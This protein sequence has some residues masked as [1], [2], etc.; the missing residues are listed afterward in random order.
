MRNDTM[1]G[2]LYR[3]Q[4][5]SYLQE[6]NEILI[7][8]PDHIRT[9]RVFAAVTYD[10]RHILYSF[11]FTDTEQ[12]QAYLD[13][14]KAVRNMATCWDES[15]TV[16]TED[17]IITLSTCNGNDAQRFLVEAVLVDET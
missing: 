7:Y 15:V 17:R 8:T 3:Y 16:T 5:I 10:N 12:Y 4:D 9:Y 2:G 1:F 14:L 13:S 6:H 11:D